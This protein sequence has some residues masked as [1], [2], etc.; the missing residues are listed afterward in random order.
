M[1]SG[2]SLVAILCFDALLSYGLILVEMALYLYT[3]IAF[4]SLMTLLNEREIMDTV[5][6]GR[7]KVF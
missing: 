4:C 7:P 6:K 1:K 3:S 2:F 5:A